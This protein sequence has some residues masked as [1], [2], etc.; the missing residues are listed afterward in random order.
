MMDQVDE[1]NQLRNK[2]QLEELIAKKSREERK[3]TDRE[4]K[5]FL[6]EP[7][8]KAAGAKLKAA[9]QQMLE[10]SEKMRQLEAENPELAEKIGMIL[11]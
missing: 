9:K 10:S 7:E 4:V 11:C 6:D 5:A 2:I 8:V 1:F 3:Q